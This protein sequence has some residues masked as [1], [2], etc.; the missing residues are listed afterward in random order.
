MEWLGF[1]W[2]KECYASDYFQELYD[3]A[4]ELIKKGKAYVDSQSSEDM[5]IQ[6]GTPTTPGT[7]SPFRNRTIEENLDLFRKCI[8][9]KCLM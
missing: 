1:T 4:V 8:T 2:D 7:D 9:N 6:K 3:W 5:A